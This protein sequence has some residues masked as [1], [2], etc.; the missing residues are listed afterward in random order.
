MAQRMRY[1]LLTGLECGVDS[2]SSMIRDDP[3]RSDWNWIG[4]GDERLTNVNEQIERQNNP[5]RPGP[6]KGQP[7]DI[8]NCIVFTLVSIALRGCER[9]RERERWPGQRPVVASLSKSYG[10]LSFRF[11][12]QKQKQP[13]QNL[14]QSSCVSFGKHQIDRSKGER[15]EWGEGSYCRTGSFVD[16]CRSSFCFWGLL[17]M[18]FFTLDR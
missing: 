8:R 14:A 12:N 4:V 1:E 7:K 5:S 18:F 10:T 13:K 17:F 15:R 2:G 9:E 3:I 16:L 6:N 11:I